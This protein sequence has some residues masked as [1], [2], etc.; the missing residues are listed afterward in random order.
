MADKTAPLAGEYVRKSAGFRSWIET[1]NPDVRFVAEPGRY[2]LYVSRNCPW[3]HRTALV[4]ELKGLQDVISMDVLGYRRSDDNEW[5]FR[6]EI[7]G[8]TIDRVNGAS[9]MREIYRIADPDYPGSATVPVVLDKETGSIVSNESA[10]IIRMFNTAFNAWVSEPDLDLYP[11]HLRDDI[12]AS[13]DWTYQQLNNGVYR[14]GFAE[15]QEAYELA[16]DDVFA[17]L[18][19][20][21][22]ILNE[23]AFLCGDQ[24]TEADVRVFVTL[25]RFDPVYFIRFKCNKTMIETGYSQLWSYLKRLY[26]TPGFAESTNLDHIKNGY[27]GRSGNEIVPRGWG[28][29]YLAKLA[30]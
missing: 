25:F 10:E 9:G 4:R 29:D 11:S 22:A 24:L 17:A 1:D 20:L 23:N 21:E 5:V 19:R 28:N 6:P 12:D 2:H 16:F 15:S 13:N 3:S 26:K 18:D 27:F 8:C 7:E 30:R 14:A